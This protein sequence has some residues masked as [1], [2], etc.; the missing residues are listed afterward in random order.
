VFRFRD[1]RLS[2]V[3]TVDRPGDH[4][5]ARRILALGLALT[6]D[7]AADPGHDLKALATGR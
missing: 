3:E 6:P 1:G 5:A 4:M 2:A 7:A